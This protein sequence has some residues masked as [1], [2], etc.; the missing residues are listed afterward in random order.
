MMKMNSARTKTVNIHSA[1]IG[2][3]L[4]VQ[5]HTYLHLGLV[6]LFRCSAMLQNENELGWDEDGKY[7]PRRLSF[8][9]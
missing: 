9:N 6:F 1:V 4:R 2:Q 5:F 8:K 3:K 7:P